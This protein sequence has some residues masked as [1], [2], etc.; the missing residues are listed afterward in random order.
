MYYISTKTKRGEGNL[1]CIVE[2]EDSAYH[3][4]MLHLSTAA[5]EALVPLTNHALS[6]F[7]RKTGP[8][9]ILEV[10]FLDEGECTLKKQVNMGSTRNGLCAPPR[11]SPLS[12]GLHICPL[13]SGNSFC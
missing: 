12:L 13:V 1:E 5:V 4:F 9:T 3:L 7:S 6:S 8:I 10:L 2:E 11:S